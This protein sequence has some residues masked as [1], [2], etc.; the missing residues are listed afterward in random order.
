M[1]DLTVALREFAE[2]FESGECLGSP[3]SRTAKTMRVQSEP[4]VVRH[5]HG[6]QR[7]LP[8]VISVVRPSMRL[9]LASRRLPVSFDDFHSDIWMVDA[10]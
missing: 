6:A 2:E 7:S 10:I 1:A 5:Y 3:P 8:F 4:V 9:S